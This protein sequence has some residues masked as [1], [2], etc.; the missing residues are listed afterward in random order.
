[1]RTTVKVYRCYFVVLVLILLLVTISL[2]KYLKSVII[3]IGYIRI[4][5]LFFFVSQSFLINEKL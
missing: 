3:F 4:R 2:I 1:M 5:F